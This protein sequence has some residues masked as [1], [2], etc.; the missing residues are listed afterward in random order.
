MMNTTVKEMTAAILQQSAVD[1]D[2]VLFTH[3]NFNND[4]GV[5]LTLLRLTEQHK[6]AVIELGANHIGEIAYT[7]AL[8]Q[9]DV[10]LVIMWRRHIWKD[11][12]LLMA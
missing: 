7:T 11:L 4:I 5:P 1:F 12:V 9:P 2:D 6:F 3:G 8:A 10:A